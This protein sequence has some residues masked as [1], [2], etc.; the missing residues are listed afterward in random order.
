MGDVAR[1][2]VGE[3]GGEGRARH[4]RWH[5]GL[6]HIVALIS[7]TAC[8]GCATIGSHFTV[9]TGQ[10][11]PRIY[12]PG[13][14]PGR[15]FKV[16]LDGFRLG[17]EQR[18]LVTKFG[19]V[20]LTQ[21]RWA[22]SNTAAMARLSEKTALAITEAASL[23]AFEDLVEA[24]GRFQ[25]DG[26]G[27]S[28]KG[29]DSSNLLAAEALMRHLP[30]AY[31]EVLRVAYN[32]R[33]WNSGGTT[34]GISLDM[35]AGMRLRLENSVA[36]PPAGINEERAHP[37]AFAAPT[38]LYFHAL[39]ARE[40]CDPG[41]VHPPGHACSGPPTSTSETMYFLSASGGLAR[42]GLVQGNA[43]SIPWQAATA[44]SA[45][46]RARMNDLPTAHVRESS[47]LLDLLERHLGGGIGAS[48][49]WRLWLPAHRDTWLSTGLAF[50]P[51]S[52]EAQQRPLLLS[53]ESLEHL[54]GIDF[55]SSQ[56]CGSTT[57]PQ[58]VTCHSLH[59]RVMPV[60][61]IAIRVNGKREWV[62]VGTTLY[63]LLA[64]RLHAGFAS[65]VPYLAAQLAP[66]H[67][68]LPPPAT[69]E[70][71]YRAVLEGVRIQRF[72]WHGAHA[73]LPHTLDDAT[74]LARFMRLQLLPGDDIK[75]K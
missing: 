18:T 60:P 59:Y 74:Q 68:K 65:R 24:I 32:H 21:S 48:T 36:I 75:W 35:S 47:S 44:A 2:R 8:T 9:D 16:P 70:A 67:D 31:S 7:V 28:L 3:D 41:S 34:T 10:N 63:D 57:A 22:A 39:T 73:L 56:P 58:G 4:L 52:P 55:T 11:D 27:C 53:A 42:I 19:D 50:G 17:C 1:Y 66:A 71:L 37:S 46:A 23:G 54:Q 25:V 29:G 12:A 38:Y 62:P 26:S 40:L 5:A 20:E 61:E 72:S 51:G 13:T 30:R 33:I 6:R 14:A 49:W 69:R 15:D 45:P 64:E 43:A